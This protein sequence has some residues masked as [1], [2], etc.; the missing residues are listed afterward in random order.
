MA[1]Q[2]IAQA[3]ANRKRAAVYAQ[4][5]Y[6]FMLKYKRPPAYWEIRLGVA[7]AIG[8]LDINR[9]PKET[10][11]FLVCQIAAEVADAMT[12]SEVAI[13]NAPEG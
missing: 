1:K 6:L 3:M 9:M 2:E 11:L 12:T 8:E 13:V 5:D 10:G 4:F 7:I